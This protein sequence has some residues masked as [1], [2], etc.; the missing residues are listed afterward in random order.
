MSL[1]YIGVERAADRLYRDFILGYFRDKVSVAQLGYKGI[2][3]TV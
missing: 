1:F 2:V 3:Q